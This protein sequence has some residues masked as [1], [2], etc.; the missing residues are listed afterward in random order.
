MGIKGLSK[1]L[2]KVAPAAM[3]NHKCADEYKDFTIAIDASPCL[4]QCMTAMGDCPQGVTPGSDADTSHVLGFL[5]RTVRLLEL[6]MKPVFIF[7]GEAPD[8]K[9]SHVLTQR[10]KMRARSR[11]QLED[12]K[13]AGDE[14]AI[15]RCAARLVKT[16][17]RH[18]DEV[19]ELLRLMG[20]PAV[21]APGEAECLC[22]ALAASGRADAAAT[23][24]MDALVFGAPRLLRN[25]H[26]AA[27]QHQIPL[28]QDIRLDS[29]LK[30]ME[31]KQSEFVDFCILAGCDYLTTIPKVGIVTASELVKKHRTIE[32]ILEG[33]DRK[34][35]V[36]PEDWNYHEAR[37]C[38]SHPDLNKISTEDLTASRPDPDALRTLLCERHKLWPDTVDDCIRRLMAVSGGPATPL[39]KALTSSGYPAD[40]A[41]TS[42][43][44]AEVPK[45]VQFERRPVA[46]PGRQ[47][48]SSKRAAPDPKPLPK[49][50]QTLR[51][52]F[53][54]PKPK[55]QEEGSPQKRRRLAAVEVLEGQLGKGV[56]V[57][58]STSL[59]ELEKLASQF[60][61]DGA[62][63]AAESAT[64]IAI[65]Q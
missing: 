10:E 58:A 41:S 54:K 26:R 63:T 31:L 55:I 43:V 20:V 65:S 48:S 7:D 24:D 33:L 39:Q 13:A 19:M 57:P 3:D 59:D 38:F 37:A 11:E 29:I 64:A 44:T 28:V 45:S 1:F 53:S 32:A 17:Q 30:A 18:N 46:T 25:I 49:G 6:G 9:K 16:T 50:Q 36:V 5:R 4:Y 42:S 21:Q 15:R 61:D 23:E 14:D 2:K 40:K 27:S 47:Q 22:A 51:G 12:A 52:L 34:K 56:L 35:H 62:K 8:M 60:S